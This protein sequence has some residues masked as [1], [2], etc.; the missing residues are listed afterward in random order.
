MK[1]RFSAAAHVGRI[2]GL[3]VALGVGAAVSLGQGV[4]WADSEGSGVSSSSSPS[5]SSSSSSSDSGASGGVSAGPSSSSSAGAART[6]SG[7]SS[8]RTATR[9]SRTQSAGAADESPRSGSRGA[10]RVAQ[11]TDSA[12]QTGARSTTTSET[13]AATTQQETT[14]SLQAADRDAPPLADGGAPQTPA[15]NPAVL[16]L[17][18]FA[19]R[20]TAR[21]MTSTA[22]TTPLATQSTMQAAAATETTERPSALASTPLGWVTGVNNQGTLDGF[23]VPQTNDT[24]SFDIYGTDLGI[25]WDGGTID[26]QRFVHLAFG[27]TFSG[28]RM[29]G[30]WRNNVL[31]ISYDTDFY[32]GEQP[33]LELAQTGPAFQFIDRSTTELGFLFPTEVTV[34]PTAGIQINGGQFV[35]YMSVRSW[36]TPG[37][38]TTNYSAISQFYPGENGG[39]WRVVPSTI[40]SAGWFRSSTP[41]VAGNQNFQQFAYVLQPEDQVPEN[42]IRYLYAFGTPSGRAGSAYLSR[43]P[44]GSITDL[45]RYEYW[46][47]STWVL[48]RPAAAVPIIGDS[49][50]S[51]G[52]FGFLIDFANDPNVFGGYLGGLFGA[53]TGGNVSEMSV[54]YNEYLDQYIVLY[55][56]GNNNIQM[57]TA[58]QP[59]GPWSSPVTLARSVD[60]PG[61][62][63]P[64]IHPWSGTGLLTGEDGE[65]DVRTLYWNMSIWGDYNVV[66]M[67]TDL[68]PLK[69]EQV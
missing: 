50:R 65:P 69:G 8:D 21:E 18:A 23:E 42:G 59:Q 45:S 14:T 11:Q 33:G 22:Q 6:S 3:A 58:S 1:P 28:P 27:D 49:T 39:D 51:T 29:T 64:M 48:G 54:Q 68:A 38:W 63:A 17:M 13:A 34:I 16:G 46:N 36:D 32:T 5:S 67:E 53:K 31:L 26:G 41:Y 25:M 52:L 30:N 47:G 15:P 4:A 35:N 24:S 19:R 9:S 10:S 60:Y 2:G 44:E 37:R 62:Y 20:E 40:R 43:V 61:L 57:R 55:G 12:A 66:L 56:D 7:S